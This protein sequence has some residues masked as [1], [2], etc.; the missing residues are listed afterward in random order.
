M[1]KNPIPCLPEDE[2]YKKF[3][4]SFSYKEPVTV[5]QAAKDFFDFM[6]YKGELPKEFVSPN[7]KAVIASQN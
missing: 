5:E 3:I 1:Y 6:Q 2:K 7:G 4:I